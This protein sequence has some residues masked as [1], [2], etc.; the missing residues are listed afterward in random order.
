VRAVIFANG[1]FS[2]PEI[3]RARL[4]PDDWLIAADGGARHCQTLGL[5]PAVLIGD[6][7]SIKIQARQGLEQQGVT[8]VPF[9]ESKDETDLE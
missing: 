3:D 6:F 2:H 1:I 7:D 5:T 8:V 4:R 9:P